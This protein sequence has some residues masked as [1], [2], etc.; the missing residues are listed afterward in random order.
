MVVVSFALAVLVPLRGGMEQR[1]SVD[2]G[3]LSFSSVIVF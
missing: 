1:T 3:N 2:V